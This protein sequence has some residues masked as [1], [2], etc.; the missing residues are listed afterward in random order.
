MRQGWSPGPLRRDTR[1]RPG[2]VK[3]RQHMRILLVEDSSRLREALTKAFRQTGY[4][5]DSEENGEE[6]LV[7]DS[8]PSTLSGDEPL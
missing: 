4:A 2:R 6:G 3:G 5:V 1:T 8:L 7:L